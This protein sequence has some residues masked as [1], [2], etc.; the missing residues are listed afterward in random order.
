MPTSI[1]RPKQDRV[2][3]RARSN[4]VAE[5]RAVHKGRVLPLSP[6]Q[7][8]PCQAGYTR[9]AH[10]SSVQMAASL[11][12]QSATFLEYRFIGSPKLVYLRSGSD[13]EQ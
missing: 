11:L 6:I 3:A 9:P 2:S 13:S 8:L 4:I 5:G 10:E 12:E 7:I 1:A